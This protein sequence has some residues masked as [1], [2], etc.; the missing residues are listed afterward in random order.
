MALANVAAG[1]YDTPWSKAYH[2]TE[3]LRLVKRRALIRHEG[4]PMSGSIFVHDFSRHAPDCPLECGP[5]ATFFDES[6]MRRIATALR[7]SLGSSTASGG[8]VWTAI[9]ARHQ[10]FVDLLTSGDLVA[11]ANILALMFASPLTHGFEQFDGMYEQ[12]VANPATQQH[13]RQLAFDRL[14][15]LAASL[16]AIPVQT[17]EQGDFLPYLQ[18]HPDTLLDRIEGKIE[19]KIRAPHFHGG[20]FGLQTKRGLFTDRSFTAIYV[21]LRLREL[22]SPIKN[23]R[24]CEIGGGA[25]YVAYFCNSLGLA[26]YTIVDLPTVSAV[27]AYFLA[28]NL[29]ADRISLSG[30]SSGPDLVKMIS[31]DDFSAREFDVIV[32]VDSFPEMSGPIMRGYLG[33]SG[34]RYLL[35]INQEAMAQRS[36]D[37]RQERVGDVIEEI[38]GFRRLSRFPFWMRPGY[39]EELYETTSK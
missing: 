27:Q 20:L 25:G 2:P 34:F 24:I 38:G 31:A 32:N 21:A 7:R 9:V 36:A 11:G 3:G 29:G 19:R 15:S 4:T 23:P 30:E 17:V 6:I 28:Q 37:E 18:E 12:I 5:P 13:V 8:D 10:N 1:V 16:R 39:V 14:L 22:L 33:R 26:D 35:S